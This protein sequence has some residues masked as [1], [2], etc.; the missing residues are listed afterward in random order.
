MQPVRIAVIGAGLIGCK[1]IEYT[2]RCPETELVA[3]A[4]PNPAA[5]SMA[6]TNGARWWADIEQMLAAG[7]IDGAIVA[8]PTALHEPAGM[9]CINAGVHA[10]I[11]KPVCHTLEAAFTPTRNLWSISPVSKSQARWAPA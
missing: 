9:H 1:H 11:E 8:T 4:D 2:A 5:R 10:I 7:G 3:V 6:E